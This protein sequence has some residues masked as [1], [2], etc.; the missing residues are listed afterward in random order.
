MSVTIKNLAY[1]VSG[2]LMTGDIIRIVSVDNEKNAT[3]Y[4]ELMFVEVFATTTG[5]GSH[6]IN[7]QPEADENG[8]FN[9]PV[10]ITVILQDNLQALRL[11][12]C[13]NTNLHAIFVS[14]DE[15]MKE[16][17]IQMQLE[18]LEE[19][20]AAA[21]AAQDIMNSELLPFGGDFFE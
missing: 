18:I 9:L 17:Y 5:G 4:D 2:K 11:A 12:E 10:T 8:D 20:K 15:T 13:E 3:I 19:I 1:G 16:T 21:E 14:R 7:N 6:N